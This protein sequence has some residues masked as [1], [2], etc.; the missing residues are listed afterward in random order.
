MGFH[1]Y[2]GEASAGG[3]EVP[4]EV[5]LRR[6]PSDPI[7]LVSGNGS[8]RINSS[9]DF[10]GVIYAPDANVVVD[11]SVSFYGGLMADVVTIKSSVDFHLDEALDEVALLNDIGIAVASSGISSRILLVQ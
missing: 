5:R 8:V 6:R 9:V 7:V 11:S 4:P 10:Y 2:E 1:F 3:V